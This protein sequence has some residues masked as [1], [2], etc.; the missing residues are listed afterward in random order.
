MRTVRARAEIGQLE[1]KEEGKEKEVKEFI[2]TALTTP[3]LGRLGQGECQPQGKLTLC[4]KA[5][6]NTQYNPEQGRT[7][8]AHKTE[9]GSV[10]EC[11]LF[12][13]HKVAVGLCVLLH[14][15]PKL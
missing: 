7:M 4:R 8:L 13:S 10:T 2:K 1:L 6:L 5:Y 12:P 11:L 9:M 3:A 14:Y 15:G